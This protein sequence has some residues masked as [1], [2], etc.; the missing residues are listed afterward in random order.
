M[1]R[2]NFHFEIIRAVACLLVIA[3]HV[4][5]LYNRAFPEIGIG[6]YGIA[7]LVNSIAR[8]SVPL[9]F[10]LSG[11][12]LAG[13]KPD[14]H[15]SIHRVW[16][17]LWITVLWV[18]FYLVWTRVYLK[19]P[20]DFRMLLSVPPS[21]HL[22]FLYAILAIYL[23][24]PLIQTLTRAMDDSLEL[25][26][27]M[28]VLLGVSVGGQYI[29]SF[30]PLHGKY[31]IPLAHGTYFGLFFLG[32]FLYEQRAL[33]RF[34]VHTRTLWQVFIGCT[35][36]NAMLTGGASIKQG[37][38]NEHFF[39]YRSPLIIL[40][41]AAAFVLLSRIP[42][43][44]ISER[45]KCVIYHVSDNS[46]GIYLLHAVFLNIISTELPVTRWPALVGIPLCTAVIY[47]V[48]DVC[49]S[50]YHRLLL[51]RDAQ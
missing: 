40:A 2:R 42:L 13:R 21:T 17:F 45:M 18:A 6:S 38:H 1:K 12:L 11:A 37:V 31:D 30:T 46:F 28:L 22:W 51:W 27:W 50:L 4:S 5:N 29:L 23:A 33:I 24:L 14:I 47:F 39:E 7:L 15:K 20:Y 16:K 36:L 32:H 19:Q 8:V 41:S 34:R 3:I 9:F 48:T 43:A 35:V 44:R 26:I 10:M 49:I 25:H